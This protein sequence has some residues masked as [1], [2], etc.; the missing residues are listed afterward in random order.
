MHSFEPILSFTFN[1][2]IVRRVERSLRLCRLVM[3]AHLR[4]YLHAQRAC[5]ARRCQDIENIAEFFV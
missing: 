3:R 1:I 4:A 2:S 5:P